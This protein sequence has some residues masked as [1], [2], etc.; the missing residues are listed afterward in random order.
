M[1]CA[2]GGHLASRLP[3]HAAVRG[4]IGD[5]IPFDEGQLPEL[6]VLI[7]RARVCLYA[8]AEESG[9]AFIRI[10]APQGHVVVVDR[11]GSVRATKACLKIEAWSNSRAFET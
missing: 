5:T 11:T 3:H 7:P 10:L 8:V 1:P 4:R 2:C 6:V 9:L